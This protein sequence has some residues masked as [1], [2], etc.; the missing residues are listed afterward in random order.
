MG[1]ALTGEREGQVFSREILTRVR[2][3]S[4]VRVSEGQHR[5]FRHREERLDPARSETL[6]AHGSFPRGDREIPQLAMADGAVARVENPK[7]VMR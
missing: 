5:A 6:C 1:E 2:G 4:A 7:G 3:V